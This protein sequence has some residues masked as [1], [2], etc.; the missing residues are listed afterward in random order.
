MADGAPTDF[1][2]REDFGAEALIEIL[3][4]FS[5][6]SS[7]NILTITVANPETFTQAVT[8]PEQYNLLRVRTGGWSNFFTSVFPVIQDQHR[9]RPM[10]TPDLPKERT[11]QAKCP[12]HQW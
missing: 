5:R 4:Q 8:S 11:E 6:G 9:R 12:F 2:I 3:K 1:N 10:S 7:S